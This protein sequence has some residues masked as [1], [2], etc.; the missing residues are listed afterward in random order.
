MSKKSAEC[1]N[2]R[3]V[4]TNCRPEKATVYLAE[5]RKL[6][7]RIGRHRPSTQNLVRDSRKRIAM[8]DGGPLGTEEGTYSGDSQVMSDVKKR[9]ELVFT[10]PDHL[11]GK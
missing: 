4:E 11:E 5:E 9:Q 7:E 6:V 3:E 10:E 8:S 2:C 1:P